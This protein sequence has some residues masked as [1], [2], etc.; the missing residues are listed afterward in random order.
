MGFNLAFKR[1]KFT[2]TVASRSGSNITLCIWLKLWFLLCSNL[3][4]DIIINNYI[5][6]RWFDREH[7]ACLGTV[8][9]YDLQ[10]T[11]Y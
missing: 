9:G 5:N 11:V 4:K 3:W 8:W 6:F 7:V 10:H 1:L 2:M